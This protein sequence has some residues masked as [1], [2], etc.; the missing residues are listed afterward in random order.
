MA[1]PKIIWL[2]TG[3]IILLNI[4]VVCFKP[5][6]HS[7]F[8]LLA[9]IF[10][11]L[12]SFIAAYCLYGAF[13]SLRTFDKAKFAWLMIY[14]GVLLFF[15]AECIFAYGESVLNI[16]MDKAFPTI[17]DFVWM[18]AYIPLIIGSATIIYWYNKSGF[19]SGNLRIYAWSNLPFFAV[20]GV[21]F[22]VILVPIAIDAQTK[23]MA[24]FTYL[25]Y[26]IVDLALLIGAGLLM[27]ITS[28]FGHGRIIKSWRCLSGGFIVMTLADLLY[29][30]LN[31]S[32]RYEL[33][34]FIDIGWPL[35]YLLIAAAAA[36]QQELVRSF[37]H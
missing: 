17:A 12:S 27:Y 14:L 15:A 23:T 2:F 29:S 13:H 3:I 11:I 30:Y 33:G 8:P 4:Y 19:I 22:A 16:D 37:E 25:Y 34:N 5:G 28:L 31:W 18:A 26:P 32:G 36:Y 35:S 24:K 20:S 21:L 1:K 7:L 10:P 9:D 6:G